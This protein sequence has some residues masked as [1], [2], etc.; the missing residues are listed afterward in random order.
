MCWG[1]GGGVSSVW[2][3]EQVRSAL[4]LLCETSGRSLVII[5]IFTGFGGVKRNRNVLKL[6]FGV[7]IQA[8]TREE[9]A[10]FMGNGGS[11]Y[12][13][14]LYW[15][16]IVNLTGYCKR[17]YRITLFPIL[18]LFYLFVSIEFG[19]AK[20]TVWSVLKFMRLTLNYSVCTV[21]SSCTHHCD[22]NNFSHSLTRIHLLQLKIQ[23]IWMKLFW[24]QK[25]FHWGI[26]EISTLKSLI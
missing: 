19:K 5:A 16:F 18:L 9:V 25:I 6:S 10:A 3:R 26:K 12:V 17:F 7:T 23:N 24:N 13:L 2:R 22:T 4:G 1:R 20:S 8:T 15:N 14:L 21:I 11:H